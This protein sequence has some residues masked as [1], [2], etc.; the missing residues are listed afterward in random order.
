M[1]IGFALAA[2]I[3]IA[4]PVTGGAVNPARAIGPMLAAGRFT[5]WWAYLL[6]GLVGGTAAV[7]FYDRVLRPGLP[8]SEAGG[9]R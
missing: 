5:D 4:G 1:A 9:K 6:G 3:L 8:P 2:A 7:S